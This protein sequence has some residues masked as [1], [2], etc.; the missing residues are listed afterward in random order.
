MAVIQDPNGYTNVRDGQNGPVIAKL[1]TGE[2]FIAIENTS[3]DWWR[4]I[5]PSGAEGVIHR[6]RTHRLPEEPLIKLPIDSKE[7][8]HM[9]KTKFMGQRRCAGLSGE[10]HRGHSQ[11]GHRQLEVARATV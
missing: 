5:L 7:F 2:R 3:D 11:S 1:K 4:V 9:L 6:S 8:F 10:L